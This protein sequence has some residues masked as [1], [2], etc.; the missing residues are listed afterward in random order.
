MSLKISY[1]PDAQYTLEAV[2]YYIEKD[3]GTRSADKFLSDT[4]KTL[5]LISENP[6]MFRA[7]AF[8][9]NVRVGFISKQTSLFYRVSNETIHL[10]FFWNNRQEPVFPY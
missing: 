10:L 4:E 5:L 1:T 6:L 7:S 8:D 9:I 2:Y 3:F